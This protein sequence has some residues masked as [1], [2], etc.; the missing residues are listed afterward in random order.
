VAPEQRGQPCQNLRC[1]CPSHIHNRTC[2]LRGARPGSLVPHS[3]VVVQ[4]EPWPRGGR[5]LAFL[6]EYDENEFDTERILYAVGDL[7]E[8]RYVLADTPPHGTI[9]RAQAA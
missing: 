9:S 1:G 3:R 6:N 4:T 7:D 2:L 8:M 5:T